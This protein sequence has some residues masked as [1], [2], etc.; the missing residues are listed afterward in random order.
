MND[1]EKTEKTEKTLAALQAFQDFTDKL[2]IHRILIALLS[3]ILALALYTGY[4]N[5][6]AIFN[7]V[8]S[9]KAASADAETPWDVT[10]AT[11]AELTNLVKTGKLV[12]LVL[13]TQV[14]LRKNKRTPSFWY[15]DDPQVSMIKQKVANMLPTAVF[16]SDEKNTQQ[17]VAVL[18]NTF[19]CTKYEDTVFMRYFP[20]LKASTPIIC[21]IAVPPFYGRF[22]GILTFGL[23]A[24]PTPAQLDALRI[25][26]ARLSIQIYLR[27]VMHDKR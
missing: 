4:E 17:I 5:R 1:T 12:K 16:D 10:P 23:R 14:D 19:V 18:N 27:D 26:A 25:E 24:E 6:T 3:G 21:R 13:L 22:V 7:S 2:T 11:T 9:T 8:V 15:L 20:E